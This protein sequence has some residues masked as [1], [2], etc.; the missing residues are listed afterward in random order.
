MA[1]EFALWRSQLAILLEYAVSLEKYSLV[2]C[3]MAHVGKLSFDSPDCGLPLC[4]SCRVLLK[5]L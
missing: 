2:T 4:V 3:I 5:V 1:E